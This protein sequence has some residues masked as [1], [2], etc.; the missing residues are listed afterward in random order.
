MRALY[1]DRQLSLLPVYPLPPRKNGEALIKVQLAG[2][3]R[4][5]EEILMGYRDFK[6]VLG[7][8]FVG[9]VQDATNHSLIGKRVV[10]EINIGCGECPQCRKGIKEH[11]TS[12]S[13]IGIQGKD[14]CFADYVT[15]PEENLHVLPD[16]IGNDRA[17]FIEPLA[18]AFNIVTSIWVKPTDRVA[19]IGDG[20]LGILVSQV[21]R[22]N[23]AEVILLGKHKKKLSI[24]EWM[25]IS[26][27]FFEGFDSSGVKIKSLK[28]AESHLERESFDVIVECS[29]SPGGFHVANTLIAPRGCLVLKSTIADKMDCDLTGIVVRELRVIGSRCG[30]FV[31]AIRALASGLIEVRPLLM[32][33]FPLEDWEEAFEMVR[34]PDSLK[35][36]FEVND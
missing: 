22:M 28:G 13:V 29:G 23:G 7:H 24:L 10:G 1:F 18:A 36:A 25:G 12:R 20:K 33:R 30:P 34:H 32:A 17:I 27:F 11:C 19:I 14:G 5:D 26:A 31:P 15:L 8:E 2:I 16:E 3:C 9:I 4:T 21:M 35:V 6:G